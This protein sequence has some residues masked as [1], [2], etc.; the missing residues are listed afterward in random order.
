M[1]VGSGW[2]GPLASDATRVLVP[3][4]SVMKR[5]L[6]C[7]LVL[8]CT[9]A[10]LACAVEL[11]PE[12][13]P[14]V[15]RSVSE[16]RNGSL[17]SAHPAV[18]FVVGAEG[19][20]TG[21]LISPTKVLTAAH[22]VNSTG[23]GRVSFGSNDHGPG[24]N[25][26]RAAI[27]PAW[28]SPSADIAVITLDHPVPDVTPMKLQLEPLASSLVGATVSLV[29]FGQSGS[30]GSGSGVKRKVDV[31]LG[32][33]GPSTLTYSTSANGGRT[34]DHG[35]S[36]GPA[37]LQVN[38]AEV[39]VGVCSRADFVNPDTGVY[40]RVD[41]FADW[42]AAQGV[43]A[44]NCAND[45]ECSAPE[46]C[47]LGACA[48]PDVAL[49]DP[50]AWELSGC[51]AG[52]ACTL[53]SEGGNYVRKCVDAGLL[54][55]AQGDSCGS[56]A[57]CQKGTLCSA[58]V[59]GAVCA[60]LCDRTL[61]TGC[62]DTLSGQPVIGVKTCDSQT[63][64]GSPADCSTGAPLCEAGKCV[65]CR[66]DMDCPSNGTCFFGWCAVP[67][68]GACLVSGD[69]Q[70][71]LCDTDWGRCVGCFESADCDAN[72]FCSG[73]E[74]VPYADASCD[75][76]AQTG[77]G[78]GQM[79]TRTPETGGPVVCTERGS[80]GLLSSCSRAED[81]APGLACTSGLCAPL[82]DQV[83]PCSEGLCAL[84]NGIGTCS[85]CRGNQDCPVGYEC[86]LETQV[87]AQCRTDADCPAGIAPRCDPVLRSCVAAE[88]VDAGCTGATCEP[89]PDAGIPTTSPDVGSDP[90]DKASGCGCGASSGSSVGWAF[91]AL[92]A[93]WSVSREDRRAASGTR[94]S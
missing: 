76:F 92:M 82:C 37:I 91:I 38:G 45:S 2:P 24:L 57:R 22:C 13:R 89:E 55:R 84:F 34:S 48:D 43:P 17:D 56:G 70:E 50:K 27:H 86:D 19:S 88:E 83:H 85:V 7:C 69:C 53:E 63:S 60:P 3:R 9:Q 93:L 30:N 59:N 40:V 44:R 39:V 21:T 15:H 32:G 90:A 29:G 73:G 49:C 52:Q 94:G 80:G 78:A 6:S 1:T 74:C 46:Q 16:I 20:C 4:E 54:T 23:V 75:P 72:R 8:A 31:T 12:A 11:E 68:D 77:C 81:C 41:A 62:C 71:K 18:V 87:C 25:F 65:Q 47:L 58:G 5:R 51:P 79:C 26:H 66:Q 10:I 64:C 42:I 36:G 35:D 33:M 67:S 61:P 28:P 14:T